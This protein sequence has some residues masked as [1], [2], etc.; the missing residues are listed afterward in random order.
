MN[1]PINVSKPSVWCR[2][3]LQGFFL[4]KAAP[5]PT[6]VFRISKN[7]KRHKKQNVEKAWKFKKV[8]QNHLLAIG[9][10]PVDSPS[11]LNTLRW[12]Q[13]T[14]R[15]NCP[16][17]NPITLVVNCPFLNLLSI[18]NL[19][20]FDSR[21]HLP[22]QMTQILQIPQDNNPPPCCQQAW[23]RCLAQLPGEVPVSVHWNKQ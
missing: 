7:I 5:T 6:R 14:F 22:E 13:P 23:R 2:G 18:D 8:S 15:V 11:I 9:S 3:C 16:F 4:S 1:Y 17:L 10:C 19:C 12:V 21:L 20:V